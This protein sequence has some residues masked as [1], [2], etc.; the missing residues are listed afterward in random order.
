MNLYDFLLSNKV[1]NSFISKKSK[2]KKSFELIRSLFKDSNSDNILLV[3]ISENAEFNLIKKYKKVFIFWIDYDIIINIINNFIKIIS[4]KHVVNISDNLKICNFLKFKKIETQYFEEKYISFDYNINI[5]ISNNEYYRK[6]SNY[7]EN[8]DALFYDIKN[9]NDINILNKHKKKKF[10]IWNNIDLNLLTNLKFENTFHLSYSYEVFESLKFYLLNPIFFNFNNFIYQKTNVQNENIYFENKINNSYKIYLIKTKENRYIAKGTNIDIDIIIRNLKKI[11]LNNLHIITKDILSK[12][13]DMPLDGEYYI[14]SESFLF[15][16]FKFLLNCKKNVIWLPNIDSHK[17]YNR[18]NFYVSLE[19]LLKYNNFYIWSKTKQIYNW[20]SFKNNLYINFNNNNF[21]FNK[22][23]VKSRETILI[24]TGSSTSGRKYLIEI[25]DIF[26]KNIYIPFNLLVKTVPIVFNK[27]NLKAYSKSQNIR[28]INNFYSEIEMDELYSKYLYFIYMSK[29]DGFGLSLSKA[30]NNNMFIFTCDNLP[31]NEMLKNYPRK[32][33][34]K[35]S[36]F[37]NKEKNNSQMINVPD[38]N[39]LLS[40]L[41]NNFDDIRYI[42]DKSEY[43]CKIFNLKND[44]SFVENL[45]NYFDNINYTIDESEYDCENFHFKNDN[46][47]NENLYNYSKNKILN[48]KKIFQTWKTKNLKGSMKLFQE[49]WKRCNPLYEYVIFDDNDCDNYIYKNPKNEIY[50]DIYNKIKD[51]DSKA[52]LADF[53]RYLYIYNEGGIYTDIDTICLKSFDDL[54]YRYKD[55]KIILGLESNL[56]DYKSATKLNISHPKSLALHTFISVPNNPLIKKILD[57][58]ITNNIDKSKKSHKNKYENNFGTHL[59]NKIIYDNQDEYSNDVKILDV[60][61]FSNGSWVPHS[62]CNSIRNNDESFSCHLYFASWINKRLIEFN[63]D[64]INSNNYNCNKCNRL[65]GETQVEIQTKYC[66]NK[67]KMCHALQSLVNYDE[68]FDEL[69]VYL[70]T[71]NN[72]LYFRKY[73]PAIKRNLEKNLKV[74]WNIYENN[75]SDNTKDLLNLY[76]NADEELKNKYKNLI[77]NHKIIFCDQCKKPDNYINLSINKNDFNPSLFNK[78][79]CEHINSL[80]ETSW[81]KNKIGFRCEKLAIAREKLIK[82]SQKNNKISS[83]LPFPKWCLLIDTDIIFDYKNTILPLLQASESKPDGVMFCA[84]SQCVF[85]KKKII[86]NYY[87]DTFALDYGKYLWH[88]NINEILQKSYFKNKNVAKVDTAFNG[89]VL[90]KKEVLNLSGW[91]TNCETAENYYAYKNYGISEH[92][93]FCENV[94]RFG[95]IYLVKNSIAHW[96]E[97]NGYTDIKN[98]IPKAEINVKKAIIKKK[99]LSN[100]LNYKEL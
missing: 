12:N 54:L 58:I 80:K 73:F 16:T 50:I 52:D 11:N 46:L 51:S 57:A 10:I 29:Y 91:S 97:E 17:D 88:E 39:D 5:Y 69:D 84:Y 63:R 40:K 55:K 74:C 53:I 92:Y 99:L 76:F 96:M 37:K 41:T 1:N 87:Y 26:D 32:Y 8:F 15:D 75:S 31:W 14:F 68:K 7:D 3:D 71:K 28:I 85:N 79:N 13:L 6:Y 95:N 89:V 43:D 49:S 35:S 59:F 9:M 38:F 30:I 56:K 25:L 72:E 42:V 21:N 100:E 44:Y 70:L 23:L 98:L 67:L 20:L 81:P 86:D 4:S 94:K 2:Y 83:F 60:H 82:L 36:L 33:Y 77:S 93:K 64:K 65:I 66:V 19:D 90:I 62:G 61:V 34:I 47:F 22:N 24:D 18:N 48:Y 45:Y 27:Y 78:K